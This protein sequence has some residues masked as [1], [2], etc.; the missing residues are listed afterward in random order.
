MFTINQPQSCVYC[1]FFQSFFLSNN[2]NKIMRWVNNSYIVDL[3]EKVQLKSNCHFLFSFSSSAH[4]FYISNC[5]VCKF[6][7]FL[8]ILFFNAN[9]CSIFEFFLH[10]N[11]CGKNHSMASSE[12]FYIPQW[13]LAFTDNKWPRKKN[14]KNK[15]EKEFASFPWAEQKL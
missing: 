4:F 9:S 3:F 2:E 12:I 8:M 1:F 7:A 13:F 6:M 11:Y 5:L 10:L 14:N 15:F